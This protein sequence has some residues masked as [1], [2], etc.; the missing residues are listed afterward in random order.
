[1]ITTA[2]NKDLSKL[3][4]RELSKFT[5][6]QLHRLTIEELSAIAQTKVNEISKKDTKLGSALQDVLKNITGRII[7]NTAYDVVKSTHP[8]EML[9]HFILFLQNLID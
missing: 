9:E 6:D 8:D 2:T 1:M 7:A 3:T 5:Q 4:N